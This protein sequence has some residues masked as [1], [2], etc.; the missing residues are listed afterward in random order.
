MCCDG[1]ASSL[2][3]AADLS[4]QGNNVPDDICGMDADLANAAKAHR[5][6]RVQLLDKIREA[7]HSVQEFK[8]QVSIS[9]PDVQQS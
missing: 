6:L 9:K 2:A 8:Q 1:S 7:N 3:P 5:H 4:K